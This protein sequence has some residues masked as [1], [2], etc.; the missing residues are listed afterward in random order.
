MNAGTNSGLD[1]SRRRNNRE[2]QHS[3]QYRNSQITSIQWRSKK[4][5]RAYYGMQT[6]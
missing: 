1:S 2:I 3:V 5:G 6:R 4:S